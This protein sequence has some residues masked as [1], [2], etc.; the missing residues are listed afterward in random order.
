MKVCHT[1]AKKTWFGEDLW[2]Y[3][4]LH[5]TVI[6]TTQISNF[7]VASRWITKKTI[8]LMESCETTKVPIALAESRD[9]KVLIALVASSETTQT[10][11]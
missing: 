1:G 9:T 3:V 8:A 11:L 10:L 5:S 6:E 4:N 2:N 7:L